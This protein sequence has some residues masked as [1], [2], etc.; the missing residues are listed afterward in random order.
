MASIS[1]LGS[2]AGINGEALISQLL[3][4]EKAPIDAVTA[5]NTKLST[6]VSTWGRIQSAFSALQ[7][8]SAALNKNDF[9]SATTATSSD[10]N[11]VAVT[12]SNT[13]SPGSY[14]VEVQALAQAQYLATAPVASKADAFGSGTLRI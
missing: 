13:S 4:V 1:N 12:T 7:D 5:A 11:A 2:A 3:A 14:S 10:A 6:K 8:A 9:W